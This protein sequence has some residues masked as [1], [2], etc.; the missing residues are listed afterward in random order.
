MT[1]LLTENYDSKKHHYLEDGHDAFGN[2]VEPE[3]GYRLL[4]GEYIESSDR[5]F[6]IYNGWEGGG[7]NGYQVKMRYT[8]YYTGGR[9]TKWERKIKAEQQKEQTK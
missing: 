6:D 2:I 1:E 7:E 9:W 5:H 3:K 4:D 8:A